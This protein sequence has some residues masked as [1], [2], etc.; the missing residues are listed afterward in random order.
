[1]LVEDSHS[2][3]ERLQKMIQVFIEIIFIYCSFF[4]FFFYIHVYI[5]FHLLLLICFANLNT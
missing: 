3:L 5:Y 4:I 2:Q 1:M